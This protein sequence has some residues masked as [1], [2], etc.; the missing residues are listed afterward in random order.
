MWAFGNNNEVGEAYTKE[1]KDK[2]KRRR[3][4]KVKLKKRQERDAFQAQINEEYEAKT[5]RDKEDAAKGPPVLSR[6]C[7]KQ[8]F[9]Q[10]NPSGGQAGV[11]Q[12][13]T[14]RLRRF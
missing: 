8:G 6:G 1:L 13:Q 11:S 3:L 4:E 7:G 9:S 10:K 5:R 2:R 12:A 14:Q